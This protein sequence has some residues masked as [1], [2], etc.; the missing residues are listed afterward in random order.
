MILEL[1]ELR[2]ELLFLLLHALLVFVV[3]LLVGGGP[4]FALLLR[5]SL[6]LFGLFFELLGLILNGRLL[7]V[8]HVFLLDFSCGSLGL[9][10]LDDT[11]VVRY[12]HWRSNYVGRRCRSGG[13]SDYWSGGCSDYWS[14]LC[15]RGWS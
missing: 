1:L 11:R 14:N 15:R 10:G 2:G 5:L 8:G 9:F 4:L 13:G 3:L 6:L 12:G 7:L